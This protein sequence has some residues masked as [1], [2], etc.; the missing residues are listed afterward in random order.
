MR[1]RLPPA[2]DR[3]I[4][5]AST[6][7]GRDAQTSGP[8]AP[9]AVTDGALG[10]LTN[11]AVHA[12]PRLSIALGVTTTEGKTMS[13]SDEIEAWLAGDITGHVEYIA[14]IARLAGR[15]SSWDRA[16]IPRPGERFERAR[17]AIENCEPQDLRAVAHAH[18]L[19]A[20][21]LLDHAATLCDY[22]DGLER[23]SNLGV[24][25]S[26]HFRAMREDRQRREDER[27][28]ARAVA[29]ADGGV[30]ARFPGF[31]DV[32]WTLMHGGLLTVDDVRAA[33]MDGSLM[34]VKGIGPASFAKIAQ[35]LQ[36][37]EVDS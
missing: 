20:A 2:T 1:L 17:V 30:I 11:H 35:E 29:E 7:W 16:T 15:I 9:S 5:A 8:V 24:Q 26:D 4:V 28:H 33:L 27:V 19:A 31:R 13:I 12:V 6:K 25:L 10:T 36:R 3:R 23:G 37:E 21:E 34:R 18:E 32:G 14:E 22:A